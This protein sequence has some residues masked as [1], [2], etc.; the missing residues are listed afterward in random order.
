MT[1]EIVTLNH[2]NIVIIHEVGETAD[3]APFIVQEFIE[4]RTLRTLLADGR[5][6][7]W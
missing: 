3:G 6:S 4:G 7:S 2:P 5:R 1:A